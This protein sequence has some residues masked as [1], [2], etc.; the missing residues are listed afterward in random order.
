ML[1]LSSALFYALE[2]TPVCNNACLGCSNVF[3]RGKAPLSAAQWRD[4][5]AQIRP[6]AHQLRVT[7]GEPTLHPEFKAIV[8][9]LREMD[10]RFTL[11][12]NGRWHDPEQLVGILEGIPQC[13]GLLVSL[14]GATACTHEAFTGVP[15]SFEQ[16]CENIQRVIEAGL[17]VTTSTVITG[18]NYAEVGAVVALSR[19][20]GAHHSVF[21]RYV[22]LSLKGVEPAGVELRVA[23]EMIG[24]LQDEAIEKRLP[25]VKFGNCIPQCFAS[26][27][28]TGCLAGKAY[29]TIDP[30][31]NVRPCNHAPLTCGNLL[32]Q[33]IEQ[34]WHSYDM[35]RWRKMVPALCRDCSRFEICHGGCRAAAMLRGIRQ[36]PLIHQSIMEMAPTTPE[37]LLLNE[38]DRPTARFTLRPET[39][40]YVLMQRQRMIPVTPAAKPILDACDGTRTLREIQECFGQHALD[41]VGSLAKR[42]LIELVT[43]P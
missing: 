41:F 6:Y 21:N 9:M 4:I 30:W 23:M 42:G 14:H 40:G 24:Q 3:D 7:G 5:L 34:A 29:C 1:T 43:T 8:G 20:L 10:L 31:G 2:L 15:G 39:F 27:S 28:S 19:K 22:G 37:E 26:S 17:V 32:E 16:T 18:Y 36:D 33:S 35:Q 38:G 13:S 25:V 12:T 11:F